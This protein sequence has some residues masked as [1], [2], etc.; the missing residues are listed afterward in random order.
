M[1]EGKNEVYN[2]RVYLNEKFTNH[3]DG[4]KAHIC[5]NCG[6]YAIVNIDKKIYKCYTC[7][8]LAVITEIDTT[9][10]SKIFFDYLRCMN[11]KTEFELEKYN[12]YN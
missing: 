1:V 3:S 10:T 7:D 2:I 8:D 9:W 11:I 5:C 12:F 6:N 4:C